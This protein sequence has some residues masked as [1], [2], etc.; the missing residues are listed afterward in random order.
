M[1]W[2]GC[3]VCALQSGRTSAPTRQHLVQAMRAE[4]TDRRVV[5]KV[6]D[7]HRNAVIAD[8]VAAIDRH[9]AARSA[10]APAGVYKSRGP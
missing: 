2:L 10:R 3:L 8:G 4:R 5:G 6:V 9:V 1:D 7:V